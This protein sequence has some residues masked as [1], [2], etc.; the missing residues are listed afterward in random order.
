LVG[1]V[2]LTNAIK[3]S[4]GTDP[5]DV[6]IASTAEMLTISVHDYG[7]GIPHEQQPRI[8]ERFYRAQSPGQASSPGF[9]I[10]LYITFENL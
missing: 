5:I 10:G 9:G 7:V 8:F 2:L 3:Y 1:G 4:L 6:L